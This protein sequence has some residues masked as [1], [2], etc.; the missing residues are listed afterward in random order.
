MEIT[1][2]K[3]WQLIIFFLQH[4][5]EAIEGKSKIVAITLGNHNHLFEEPFVWGDVKVSHVFF[6]NVMK[7]HNR[8]HQKGCN[9]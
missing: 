2:L 9:E 3:K 1:N 4:I 5:M 6:K 8:L 7:I